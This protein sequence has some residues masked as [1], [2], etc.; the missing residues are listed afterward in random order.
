MGVGKGD[1]E[2]GPERE[3]AGGGDGENANI[4]SG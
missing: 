1:E 3:T 4:D 2:E